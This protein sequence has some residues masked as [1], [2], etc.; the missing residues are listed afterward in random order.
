MGLFHRF[1]SYPYNNGKTNKKSTE[2]NAYDSYFIASEQ[3]ATDNGQFFEFE[4][5]SCIKFYP[6]SDGTFNKMNLR[7]FKFSSSAR[8]PFRFLW[9]DFTNI[10]ICVI[11]KWRLFDLILYNFIL[12]MVSCE[13][14]TFYYCL[15]ENIMCDFGIVQMICEMR[16]IHSFLMH[17]MQFLYAFEHIF[18]L[19]FGNAIERHKLQ[20]EV[21]Q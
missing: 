17:P 19:H 18:W 5:I 16:V 15:N 21:V 4:T 11:C 9:N 6:T 2:F 10:W 8:K 20:I 14:W 1:C 7:K 12:N 3:N 13:M